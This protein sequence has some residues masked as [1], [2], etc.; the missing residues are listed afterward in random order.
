LGDVEEDQTL[1]EIRPRNVV[2]LLA[3]AFNEELNGERL[4]EELLKWEEMTSAGGRK[5]DAPYH[6]PEVPMS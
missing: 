6:V 2:R 3:K 4:K 1:R 5:P